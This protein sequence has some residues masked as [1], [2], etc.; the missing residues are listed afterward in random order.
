MEIWH[1]AFS[2]HMVISVAVLRDLLEGL[3]QGS[4]TSSHTPQRK[5]IAVLHSTKVPQLGTA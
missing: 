1:L 5:C 3:L 2:K 4:V